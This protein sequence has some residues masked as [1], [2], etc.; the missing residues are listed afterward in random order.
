MLLSENVLRSIIREALI[1]EGFWDRITDKKKWGQFKKSIDH[2]A[3]KYGVV[4]GEMGE[5]LD[6]V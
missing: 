3:R 2:S 6:F 4:D 5:G 1:E